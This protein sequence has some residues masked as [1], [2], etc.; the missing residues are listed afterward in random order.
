MP[1]DN[2][3]VKEICNR[4]PYNTLMVFTEDNDEY[5]APVGELIEQHSLEELAEY[6]K[7]VL[8]PLSY[9]NKSQQKKLQD[10]LNCSY[11]KTGYFKNT[12]Q[13]WLDDITKV[14]DLLYEWHIDFNDLI[15]RDI[16][17]DATETDIYENY[18]E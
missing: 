13:V 17:I 9:I 15:V 12:E 5:I 16:A 10:I 8:Y 18:V 11:S 2:L 14:I 4:I 3:R 1:V 6:G 7:L